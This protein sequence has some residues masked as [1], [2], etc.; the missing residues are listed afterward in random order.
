M[1]PMQVV[2]LVYHVDIQDVKYHLL[3][4]LPLVLVV[5]QVVLVKDFIKQVQINVFHVK[6]INYQLIILLLLNHKLLPMH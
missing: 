6:L 2:Q 4:V 1:V 5:E 3:L